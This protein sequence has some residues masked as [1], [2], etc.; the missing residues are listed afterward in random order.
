MNL[1]NIYK[2]R[3]NNI[4]ERKSI[5]K[6]L[7]KDFFQKFINDDEVVLDIACGYGE[8]IN[9]INCGKK[10]AIDLNSD[11][12]KYLNKSITFYCQ[13]S[14]KIKSIKDNFIDKI[15]ISN[16]FEHLAREDINLTIK[17]CHRVLK[18]GGQILILQPNIRF[19][20]NDYWMFFDHVTPIDDRAIEEVFSSHGFQLKKRILRFLPFTTKSNLPKS[21][22]FIKI[23]LGLPFLWRFFG[24]QSFLLFE[25][26]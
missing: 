21:S 8:F 20:A 3:F 18:K 9:E 25:K 4:E 7:V 13:S 22:I 12:A 6:V 19:C 26:L 24:Q 23:Y 15:F 11:S 14:T 16:F 5:W 17:E 2:T 1:K 10:Y